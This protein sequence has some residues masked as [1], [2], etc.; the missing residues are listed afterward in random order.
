MEG[1]GRNEEVGWGAEGGGVG[2]MEGEM[3]WKGEV[4][5]EGVKGEGVKRVEGEVLEV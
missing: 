2:R 4:G 3:G 1:G 5:V